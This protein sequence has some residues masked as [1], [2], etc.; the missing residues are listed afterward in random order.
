MHVCKEN[1]CVCVCGCVTSI[2]RRGVGRVM[3]CLRQELLDGDHLKSD[4]V[5]AEVSKIE[6]CRET[7]ECRAQGAVNLAAERSP[8]LGGGII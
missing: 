8:S 1:L 2:R 4:N 3:V 5:R 7:G 6:E